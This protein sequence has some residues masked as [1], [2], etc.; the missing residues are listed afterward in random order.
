M[1]LEITLDL[2]TRAIGTPPEG[3]NVVP[4]RSDTIR[5]MENGLFQWTWEKTRLCLFQ[6]SLR[7]QAS[8]WLERLPAGSI[9]TW[10]D[11]TTRF[12]AQFFLPKKTAKLCNDILILTIDQSAGGKLRNQN[13]KESWALLEDL[14]LYDNKSWNDPMDFAKPV[15]AIS[16]LQDVLMVPL[17]SVLMENPEQAFVKYASSRTDKAGGLMSN[18]MASQDAG[19]SKF[20]AD[21]KQ[22]Q[23]EMTNKIDTILKAII[24]R[25]IG[26]LPS[27]TVK[28]PKLN[29]NLTL[30]QPQTEMRIGTPQIEETEPTLEDESQDLHLNLP[31]LEVLGHALIY[32]VMLDQYVKSLE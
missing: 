6:F 18:V 15:K 19:L 8:N 14:A 17:T 25:M 4:P 22:Q 21:F 16:L 24:D 3:N 28:N 32:N 5:L 9:T 2:A 27:D 13:A 23:S 10:E 11:L 7:D 29:I 30:H 12:L 1:L 26:A 20:E 31:V